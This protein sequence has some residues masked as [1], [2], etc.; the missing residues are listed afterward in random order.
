MKFGRYDYGTFGAY[1]AYAASSLVIP[2]VL[3]AMALDLQ[4]PLD[5][6]G[7]AAG[8]ALHAGRSVAIVLT[9]VLSGFLAGR[10]GLRISM[11][12]AACFMGV[13]II[14]VAV[15]PTYGVVLL[16][17]LVAGL[18]EGIIEGLGTPVIQQLHRDQPG[19]YINFAHS[20][21][22]VG[23]VAAVLVSG[24]LL[25]E[26]VSWRW[27]VLGVGVLSLIPAWVYL[28]AR[29]SAE[30][31]EAAAR[32]DTADRVSWR[33]V[34]TK[35]MDIVRRPRFWLFYAMM[36]FAGGG[37]FCLTF[38]TA[39]YIQLEFKDSLMT[40]EELA[41][42]GGVGLAVFAAGMI[43]SRIGWAW[44]LRQHQLY[45]MLVG[46]AVGGIFIGLPIVW[47]TSLWWLF[48]ALFLVGVATGP[49][50]PSLQSYSTDRLPVD[51]T[52]LF[53]LLSCAGVPGCGVFT[54]VMG[55]LGDHFGGLRASYYL[56]PAC[57]AIIGVLL[58]VDRI[59]PPKS[60]A[61]AATR[62]TEEISAT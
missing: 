17:V 53:I 29:Q 42:L 23:T 35:C 44:L 52:M 4:F 41:L 34:V 40:D 2:V 39:T 60:H 9:L 57:F 56:V 22:S 20:F 21:W 30:V 36:F 59:F 7:M 12:A 26:G 37:E 49:L 31:R 14:A 58:A 32:L 38:W 25:L 10:L 50:W 47:I 45:W 3:V 55:V 18:G 43:V 15:A 8:G 54:L 62:Q 13:G 46:S 1:M 11:G 5:E 6:G 28:R 48:P 51:T 24:V 27:I 61:E 19:R 16:A 33:E